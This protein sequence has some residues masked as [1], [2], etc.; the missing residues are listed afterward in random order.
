MPGSKG[1]KVTLETVSKWQTWGRWQTVC[2]RGLQTRGGHV[3]DECPRPEL[4][5]F[6]L[7]ERPVSGR[8]MDVHL[9]F[10]ADI[11]LSRSSR[12]GLL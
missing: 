6:R 8:P 2:Y 11:N 10:L 5:H 12:E 1:L 4:A 3:A 7:S 9:T